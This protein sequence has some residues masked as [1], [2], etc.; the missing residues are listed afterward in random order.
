MIVDDDPIMRL[1]LKK[2]IEGAGCEVREAVDGE[3]ALTAIASGAT[4]D[5]LVSDINMP[6]MNGY[7]LVKGVR[8][9]LGLTGMP[10]I[11]LTTESSD[12]SQELAFSL[13][14]DDYIV[15]PFKG[16]LVIARITAALRRSGR[17]KQD[18]GQ[19]P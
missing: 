15:K 6:K 18:P 17:L 5:L 12:K 1:L 9:S 11:M 16:P 19:R 13:G 3:E 10:I 7:D 2:F 8:E 14:A 4:P